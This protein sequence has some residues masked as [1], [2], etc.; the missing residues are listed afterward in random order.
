[1]RRRACRRCGR[2]PSCS[3]RGRRSRASMSM[4]ANEPPAPPQ[5]RVLELGMKSPP[6]AKPSPKRTAMPR[7]RSGPSTWTRRA[8]RHVASDRSAALGDTAVGEDGVNLSDGARVAGAAT[9]GY[10][11]GAPRT[12][13]DHR[14]VEPRVVRGVV[15]QLCHVV[16]EGLLLG[17]DQLGDPGLL[18]LR[19][20]DVEVGAERLGDLLADHRAQRPA[21]DGRRPIPARRSPTG[22]ITNR[23][24]TST[25][26]P[27]ASASPLD[28][29]AVTSPQRR[30][31]GHCTH[32]GQRQPQRDA[33]RH[34]PRRLTCPDPSRPPR[35]APCATT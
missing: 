6:T 23:T 29:S 4:M 15:L 18:G 31:H 10:L 26:S 20:S 25:S 3:W 9:G 17:R 11:G 22:G 24:S 19:Q 12:R 30:S 5:N 28:K 2:H 16:G 21:G 14:R 27:N 35:S 32:P 34:P 1:V 13:V 8:L 7:M 33:H